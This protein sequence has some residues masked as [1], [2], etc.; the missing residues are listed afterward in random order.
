MDS[1]TWWIIIAILILIVILVLIAM[2]QGKRRAAAKRAEA[3]ELR[4]R[5]KGNEETVAEARQRA[6]AASDAAERAR[7]EADAQVEKAKALETE[8]EHQKAAAAAVERDQA[9]TLRRADRLDPDTPTD[10][11][12]NRVEGSG[13]GDNGESVVDPATGRPVEESVRLG[14]PR[15]ERP[16]RD[17]APPPDDGETPA[18]EPP[19]G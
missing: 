3:Q 18:A 1:K 2:W 7:S 16:E 15:A 10:R 12:G 11:H 19:K 17:N 5:A 6:A 8:A 13:S 4:G 9:E 14:E